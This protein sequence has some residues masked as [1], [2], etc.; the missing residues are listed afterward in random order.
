MPGEA[1]GADR[2]IEVVRYVSTVR[3]LRG[4]TAVVPVFGEGQ[5]L[6]DDAGPD[7]AVAGGGIHFRTCKCEHEVPDLCLLADARLTDSQR[8]GRRIVVWRGAC[9]RGDHIRVD[10]HSH[11]S[12]AKS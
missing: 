8:N 12:C 9:V 3:F 10:S 7:N 2:L 4:K 6:R 11:A 5:Y 1:A